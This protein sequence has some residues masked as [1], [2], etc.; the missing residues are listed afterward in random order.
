MSGPAEKIL[1][2]QAR[3]A[4][5]VLLALIGIVV[6]VWKGIEILDGR[7]AR[8]AQAEAKTAVDSHLVG[9]HPTTKEIKDDLKGTKN[10]IAR[11]ETTIA[12]M[13]GIMEEAHRYAVKRYEERLEEEQKKHEE[14][15]P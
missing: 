9:G 1:T 3:P 6:V 13:Q 14:T 11:I 15:S 10:S 7:I 2:P 12:R 5:W 8:A 4:L